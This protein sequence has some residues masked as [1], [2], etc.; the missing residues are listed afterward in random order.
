MNAKPVTSTEGNDP[1]GVAEPLGSLIDPIIRAC[2]DATI[3]VSMIIS[4]CDRD[5][6]SRTQQYQTLIPAIIQ[7]R[8]AAVTYLEFVRQCES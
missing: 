6:Q 2:P 4:T 1:S 5:Q 8:R 3:L 7:R